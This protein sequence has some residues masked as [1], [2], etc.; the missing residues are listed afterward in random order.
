MPK[1]QKR[2]VKILSM[3]NSDEAKDTCVSMIEC[4]I[5]RKTNQLLIFMDYA[6]GNSLDK[7]GRSLTELE[8]HR[9]CKR[10]LIGLKHL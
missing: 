1:L 4:F 8:I 2:E 10:L 9:I 5:L 6:N 7:I 3:F